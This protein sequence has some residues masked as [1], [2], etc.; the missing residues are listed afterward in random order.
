M[1][2]IDNVAYVKYQTYMVSVIIPTY[3]NEETIDRAIFSVV[4]QTSQDWEIIVVN[5][6]ST[7]R[8]SEI[9]AKYSN[10]GD[11]FKV[12]NNEKNVGVGISRMNGIKAA[13]G[14]FITFLDSDDLLKPDF[15]KMSM[16][17]QE[18]HNSDIVYTSYTILYPQGITQVLP[19]GDFIME[20]EG[21][22]QLHFVQE[23]KF[24][25]GKIFR[26]NILESIPWSEKRIGEDVQTLFFAT[27]VAD[28]VRSSSYSG[29]VHCFREGSLLADA[30]Y[31]F[32][33]CGS[34]QAEHEII[35]FLIEKNDER[36]WKYLLAASVNNYNI[37]NK[38]IKEGKQVTRKDVKENK[39]AFEEIKQWYKSHAK[40]IKEAGLTI[41]K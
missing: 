20:G 1:H 11:K 2:R 12:I 6:G 28:K 7:D 30:P 37:I 22:S 24:L 9:L 17:L 3:N 32:C 5:D 41:N 4:S 31:F 38:A 14:A 16:E 15:I 36:L 34:T 39:V 8:T 21:T 13:K 40:Y 10:Y 23:K 26:K 27:Y 29:Y 25:T 35:D 19:S 33:Y 18:Q